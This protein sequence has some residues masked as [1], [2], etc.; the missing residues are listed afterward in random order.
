MLPWSASPGKPSSAKVTMVDSATR[1]GTMGTHHQQI[2]AA[3]QRPVTVADRDVAALIGS[4]PS[5]RA[6]CSRVRPPPT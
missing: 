5:S 3:P 2:R 4:L 6:R 1:S